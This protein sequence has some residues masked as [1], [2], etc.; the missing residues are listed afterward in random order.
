MVVEDEVWIN[1]DGS[2]QCDLFLGGYDFPRIGCL[3]SKVEIR[4]RNDGS[5]RKPWTYCAR[6]EPT[7]RENLFN[8]LSD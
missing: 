2:A 8:H 6:I 4:L 1:N 7:L 3:V 5:Q